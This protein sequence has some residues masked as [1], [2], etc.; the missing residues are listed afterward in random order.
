MG[1]GKEPGQGGHKDF[2]ASADE[3]GCVEP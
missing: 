2:A 1:Y 3:P